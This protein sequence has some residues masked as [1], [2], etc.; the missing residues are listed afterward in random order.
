M[1]RSVID[2]RPY[3]PVVKQ[4][5]DYDRSEKEKK[6]QVSFAIKATLCDDL[7]RWQMTNDQESTD[8][9]VTMYRATTVIDVSIKRRVRWD[10]MIHRVPT[11]ILIIKRQPAQITTKGSREEKETPKD[12]RQSQSW[13]PQVD[14][15]DETRRFSQY[16]SLRRMPCTYGETQC[17]QEGAMIM[18]ARASR[19]WWTD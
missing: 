3:L 13:R 12:D 11:S 10:Q 8:Q 1:T 5:P 9:A 15:W 4:V 7:W 19:H 16:S 17:H 18:L 14:G 2:M 6:R